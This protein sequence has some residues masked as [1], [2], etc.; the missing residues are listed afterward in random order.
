MKIDISSIKWLEPKIEMD[1]DG[2]ETISLYVSFNEEPDFITGCE[3]ETL[4]EFC[5]QNKLILNSVRIYPDGKH[6][7][8]LIPLNKL[9]VE[10]K[11]ELL[12]SLRA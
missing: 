3:L 6:R 7:Y 5:E 10:E 4:L 11:R 12:N 2:K 9:T 1:N 8:L